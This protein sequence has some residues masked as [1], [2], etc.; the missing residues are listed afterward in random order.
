MIRETGARSHSTFDIATDPAFDVLQEAAAADPAS[1]RCLEFV[2]DAMYEASRERRLSPLPSIERSAASKGRSRV[3][4]TKWSMR[5]SPETREAL[6][7]VLRALTTVRL[8][9][10]KVTASGC[11]E[12]NRRNCGTTSARRGAGRVAAS[13][14]RR[15]RHRPGVRAARARSASVP[16]ASRRR[17]REGEQGFPRD[18]SAAASRRAAMAVRQQEPRASAA[19][20]QAPRRRRRTAAVC[21]R[22]GRRPDRRIRRGVVPRRAGEEEKERLAERALIEAAEGKARAPGARRR[23]PSKRSRTSR[24]RGER[25]NQAGSTYALRGRRRRCPRAGGG[26]RRFRRLQGAAGIDAA[27]DIG[28][29]ERGQAK[30]AEREALQARDEALHTNLAL[31]F[32]SQ[33]AAARGDTEAAILL[34]L[35]RFR[36]WGHGW[37]ALCRRSRGRPLPTLSSHRQARVFKHDAAVTAAVFDRMASASSPLRTTRQHAFGTSPAA[38]SKRC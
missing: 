23:A 29:G 5:S 36:A 19:G 24:H 25:G 22:K 1:L 6:P 31:S 15:G 35:E 12:R 18:A 3:A 30:A 7:A 13:G 33:Q 37:P 34:A 20:G 8:G 14:Q 11:P 16:L 32:L 21:A 26:R 9:D 27:C 28:T 4:R 2:L 17:Y 38:P 10:E